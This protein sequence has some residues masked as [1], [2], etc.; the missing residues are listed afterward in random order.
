[1]GLPV[2]STAW[3]GPV[4]Y[5]DPS[6]GI[7]VEPKSHDYFIETFALAMQQMSARPHERQEMGDCGR[8]KVVSQF[9]WNVKV[10]R[11]LEIYNSV[12]G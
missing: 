2:V 7:L 10:D 3:G 9:D 12:K 1:M 8:K 5:L 6:C 4:D 11:M